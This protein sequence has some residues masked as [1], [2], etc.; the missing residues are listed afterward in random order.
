MSRALINGAPWLCF[1]STDLPYHRDDD[2]S[3]LLIGDNEAEV[4]GSGA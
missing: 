1:V 3:Q 4:D 2:N